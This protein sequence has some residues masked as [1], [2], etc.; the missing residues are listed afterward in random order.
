MIHITNVRWENDPYIEDEQLRNKL[1][2]LNIDIHNDVTVIVGPNGCGKSRFLTS[3]EKVSEYNRK[4]LIQ[5]HKKSSY[6]YSK[7]PEEEVSITRN[8]NDPLWRILK[9]NFS[10]V[11]NDGDFSGDPLQLAKHFKSNGE[12]RDILID[13]ILNSTEELK[14]H[15]I[16]R[17]M[18]IDEIDSGLDYINQKKFANILK[19]CVNTYQFIVVSHNIPFIAQFDEIFD[20]ETLK[21]VNTKDYLNRILN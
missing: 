21:Y 18:L 14:E 2:P 16:K 8:P 20:M 19:E 7:K 1:F 12:T 9:Y 13:R 17:V 11:L 15:N 3:I 10:D 4:Q 5:E 6:S